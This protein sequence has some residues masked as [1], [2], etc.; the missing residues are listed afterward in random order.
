[1]AAPGRWWAGCPLKRAMGGLIMMPLQPS[2][3]DDREQDLADWLISQG[4][5]PEEW[6]PDPE[7]LA[8]WWMID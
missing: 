6:A 3:A 8:P 1:M 7:D 2:L 4:I 5:D